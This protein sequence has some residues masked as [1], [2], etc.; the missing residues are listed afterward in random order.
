MPLPHYI[1]GSMF[2]S[3]DKTTGLV[4]F[5]Q[6]VEKLALTSVG[7]LPADI[8]VAVGNDAWPT[9]IVVASWMRDESDGPDTEYESE[10]WVK[11]PTKPNAERLHG[12]TFEITQSFSR[13]GIHF[14]IKP[15][16]TGSGPAYI[17]NRVR[18]RY[19]CGMAIAKI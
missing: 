5:F 13:L 8:A 2:Q 12:H 17:E 3:E 19:E 10:W 11:F 15:V 4:S 18:N 14:G 7:P 6:V 16:Q 9:I 1:I